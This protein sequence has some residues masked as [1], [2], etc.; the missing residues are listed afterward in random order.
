MI[1]KFITFETFAYWLNFVV[2]NIEKM[3]IVFVNSGED[4][5]K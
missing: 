3:I 4:T 2:K 1:L 5:P